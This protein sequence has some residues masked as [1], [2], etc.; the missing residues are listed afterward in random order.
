MIDK[1]VQIS[2]HS[3]SIGLSPKHLSLGFGHPNQTPDAVLI[4]GL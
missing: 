3:R 1:H 4:G 2:N